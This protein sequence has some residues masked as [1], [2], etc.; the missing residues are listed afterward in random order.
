MWKA[1]V[2]AGGA[3]EVATQPAMVAAAERAEPLFA[4]A[5]HAGAG[6]AGPVL[7]VLLQALHNGSYKLKYCSLVMK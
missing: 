2:A 7:A 4:L 3:E 5:T 1:R 6:V